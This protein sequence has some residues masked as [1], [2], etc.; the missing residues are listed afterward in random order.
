MYQNM[1]KRNDSKTVY[2]AGVSRYLCMCTPPIRCHKEHRHSV[3]G[4]RAKRNVIPALWSERSV[5][6]TFLTRTPRNGQV[7]AHKGLTSSSLPILSS[8]PPPSPPTHTYTVPQTDRCE[9]G[10]KFGP[11]TAGTDKLPSPWPCTQR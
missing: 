10:G 11:G 1:N 2:P 3:Q 7:I 6:W 9:G 5:I 4:T 8:L